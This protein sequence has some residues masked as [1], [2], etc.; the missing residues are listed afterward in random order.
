LLT[1][2]GRHIDVTDAIRNSANERFERLNERFDVISQKLTFEKIKNEF[3]VHAEYET[4]H[5]VMVANA[6]NLDLYKGI[7]DVTDKLERQ[8]KK[9]KPSESRSH[10]KA[11]D[12][13]V[14]PV[15]DSEDSTVEV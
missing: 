5:G 14:D 3:H 7:H 12:H 9:A 4:N 6:T 10:E 15:E 13:M 2:T 8:L 1:I 11:V